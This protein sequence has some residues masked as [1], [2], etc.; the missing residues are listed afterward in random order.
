MRRAVPGARTEREPAAAVDGLTAR[1]TDAIWEAAIPVGG[2]AYHRPRRA[3]GDADGFRVATAG[4]RTHTAHYCRAPGAGRRGRRGRGVEHHPDPR[5]HRS[6]QW[7]GVPVHRYG[8][9]RASR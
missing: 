2:N 3:E 1:A 6:R 9:L 8:T 5:R 7:W 4:A